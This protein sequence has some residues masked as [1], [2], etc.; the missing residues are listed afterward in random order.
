MAT[1]I[2]HN[3]TTITPVL[4]VGWESAQDTRNVV[5]DILGRQNPDV[6][7]R[8][9]KLRT[10]TLRTLWSTVADAETCRN[11]HSDVGTFTITT[12][13]VALASMTYVVSGSITATLDEDSSEL[14]TVE[15][16]F[17]EVTT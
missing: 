8:A 12:T 3:S 11:L 13:D 4:V 15:I 14:W 1:T 6:T 17:Q 7:L 9:A 2:T 10:G 5:H 16:E